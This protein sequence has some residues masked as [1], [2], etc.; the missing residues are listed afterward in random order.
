MIF[1]SILILIVAKALPSINKNL[2]S[3]Y[4]TR[5]SSIIFLYAGVL[6][7]NTLYIQSIGSGIGIYNGLFQITQVSVLIES[8]LLIIG[9]LIL[10][11]WPNINQ[12]INT[13]LKFKTS[14]WQKNIK[15]YSGH[16]QDYSLIVL[17][18][19]LGSC[20]LISSFDLISLYISIELQSFGLYVLSTLYRDSESSTKAGLK[21]FLLGALSSCIILLGCGIIYS[22][23]GLTN[24]ESIYSIISTSNSVIYLDQAV[25]ANNSVSLSYNLAVQG[26]SL[27]LILIFIGFLFKIA[28]APLHNWSPD[29]YD[30]VPTIVTIWLTIIP[31]IAILVLLLELQYYGFTMITKEALL[32]TPTNISNLVNIIAN[33]IAGEASSSLFKNLLLI[34]SLLSLIVGTVVGLAQS[35]IKRLLAY[36]TISHIGFILLA[37]AINSESSIDS[38]IFYIIQYTITNLN[39]FLI[40]IGLSYITASSASKALGEIK[41]IKDIRYISELKGKFISNPILS[42]SLAICLFS[43]AGIPPLIGFFSKQFVL[44]S[45]IQNGYYFISIIAI[46][47][48]VISAS[49]YLKI[50]KVLYTSSPTSLA[51][52]SREEQENNN[53]SLLIS[54]NEKSQDTVASSLRLIISENNYLSNVHSYLISVLTL[55]LLLFILKPSLILNSTQLL[56]LS[57]FNW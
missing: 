54:N 19:S 23:T 38:F 13:S 22:Y 24:F 52:G 7:L 51:E 30:E 32:E 43:M 5:I 11:S 49:Y 31:K 2:P 8:F 39:V 4:F 45:A 21:Y 18:S 6:S 50:V 1:T 12:Y 15:K 53:S 56:S 44:Y 29:V 34:S 36:S 57:L 25:S 48:S 41:E 35:R 55:S 9:S 27:G 17:F 26:L 20:L 28:A 40:I 16:G 10:I 33:P 14:L 42:L 47:V 46:L 3:I 37:L